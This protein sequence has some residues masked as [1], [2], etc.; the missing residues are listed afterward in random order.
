MTTRNWNWNLTSPELVEGPLLKMAIMPDNPE[1]EIVGAPLVGAQEGPSIDR[2]VYQIEE[3]RAGSAFQA[4]CPELLITA[5][6]DTPEQAKDSLRQQVAEY[7]ED[8]DNL[9]AL[10]E[11]LI[12]AGFYYEPESEV[13][14]SSA[15]KP[16]EGPDIVIL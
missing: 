5:F 14:I 3:S 11:A 16:V 2:V 12:E 9:G 8:C 10:D 13:W 4:L 6:G 7:L 15:V 1:E